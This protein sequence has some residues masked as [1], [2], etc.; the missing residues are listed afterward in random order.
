MYAV[1]EKKLVAL[2]REFIGYRYGNEPVYPWPIPGVS[3]LK[4]ETKNT[5]SENLQTNCCCFVEA[6][7]AQAFREEDPYLRLDND[8][9][10]A[11]MAIGDHFGPVHAALELGF[12]DPT[13]EEEY[14]S[15]R[16]LVCQ[17]WNKTWSRG[18]T[19]FLVKT[20]AGGRVLILESNNAYAVRGVGWRGLGGLDVFPVVPNAPRWWTWE[21]IRTKYPHMRAAAIRLDD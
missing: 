12:A 17:G 5:S 7:L 16:W 14:E 8:Y 1:T 15:S 4:Y 18:H 20:E 13:P 9:H 3:G 6:I 11:F 2:A 10:K 19:F 21:K